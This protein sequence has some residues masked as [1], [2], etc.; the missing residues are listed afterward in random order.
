MKTVHEVSELAGVSVRTLQ[1]YDKIGL[2]S[3]A[4]RSDA[5]YRLYGDADLARLQQIL[6]FRE[7]EFPLKEIKRIIESPDFDRRRALQQQIDLLKLKRERIDNLIDLAQ[8]IK[9]T[10]VSALSFEAFN[11]DKIDEYTAEA[12]A[13]WG[14]TPEWQE[15]EQKSKG[16]TKEE[17]V[18]ETHRAMVDIQIP[19]DADETYGYSPL[20]DLPDLEYNAEKD[21]TKY[22][23]TKSQTYVT[24]KRG[25]MAIFFPQD[26]HAP[27]ISEQPTIKKAIFKVSVK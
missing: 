11:N 8:S 18:L 12:K 14:Q 10:G 21:I 26:G 13:S 6:L 4:M 19:I 9:K 3:P 20:C 2:L 5:G 15:Y 7:L 16:R 23:E 25:Q 27:C 22:G 1:Y 17:A 24:C